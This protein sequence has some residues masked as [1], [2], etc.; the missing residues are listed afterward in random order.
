[1]AYSHDREYAMLRIRALFFPFFFLAALLPV[2]STAT[3]TSEPRAATGISR[4]EIRI[5]VDLS[6]RQGDA[7]GIV[8][9]GE[10]EQLKHVRTATDGQTLVI[11][12]S[13]D[14]HGHF[15]QNRHA[16]KGVV[17]VKTL[18]ALQLMG[19][20][21]VD[22]GPFK[23]GRLELSIAGA[24]NLQMT[25]FTADQLAIAISGTGHVLGTGS[26]SDLDVHISGVGEVLLDK[27]TATAA[28]VAISG[29]GDV[30]VAARDRL[31]ATISGFGEIRYRGSP[32]VTK[33]IS[34]M[35]TVASL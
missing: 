29:S 35:G 19:T 1:M 32:S 5:P 34:G 33:T 30:K 17:T 31:E 16:I 25:D 7:E 23:T 14:S 6:I 18:T 2:S 15:W 9:T 22:F 28:R 24:G 13:D 10:P 27:L 3:P 20:G 26:V 4:I 8:L 21:S 11:D 12:D